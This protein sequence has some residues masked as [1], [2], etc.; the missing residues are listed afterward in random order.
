MQIAEPKCPHCNVIGLDHL[1]SQDSKQRNT[2]GEARFQIVHCDACG[3][4]YGVFA[5]SAAPES[6][7]PDFPG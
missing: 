6:R 5:K 3:H 4:V 7:I 2:V 1:V